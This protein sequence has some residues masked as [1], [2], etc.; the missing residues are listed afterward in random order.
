MPHLVVGGDIGDCIAALPILRQLGG[1]KLTMVPT[2]HPQGRPWEAGARLLIPL[3]KAQPYIEDVEWSPHH[4]ESDYNVSY[5][6]TMGC[7]KRD[8]SLT[9][10]QAAAIGLTEVD[11]SP[12]LTA[13][14]SAHSAGRSVFARSMRYQNPRFPWRQVMDKWGE[15]GLFL[16]LANEHAAFKRW[17]LEHYPM[18]DF[19]DAAELIAGADRLV[20]NQS[21]FGWI[22]MGMG[23]PLIQETHMTA[24]DSRLERDNCVY[25]H[26]G[27]L[28][29]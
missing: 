5:F 17:R 22:A 10:S 27:K 3:I 18:R 16:G 12:W 15:G 26:D 7:Y 4:P 21:C 1:G 25:C 13:R 19:M 14:P 2:P 23:T 28:P 20:A 8:Q 24:H 6:R 9:L 11:H 29:L